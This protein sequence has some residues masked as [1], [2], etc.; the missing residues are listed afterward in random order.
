M[1]TTQLRMLDSSGRL[2]NAR[3]TWLRKIVPGPMPRC[4]YFAQPDKPARMVL[5]GP[6]LPADWTVELNYLANSDGS[7]TL[8][9]SEGPPQKVPVRPGLNRVYARLPGR[10][11]TR[12]PC[13]PIPPRSRSA[14]RPGRWDSSRRPDLVFGA[15]GSFSGVGGIGD[16]GGAGV[17][18]GNGGNG[19]TSTSGTGDGGSSRTWATAAMGATPGPAR[20]TAPPVGGIGGAVGGSNG[21]TGRR[22][23]AGSWSRLGESNSRPIHYE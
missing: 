6:L 17:H 9:L 22:S 4:G 7:M 15:A 13:G 20:R 1:A 2:V 5:D 16:T 12:S 19:G 3:V 10:G 8:S 21:K 14:S 11:E 18:L 23:V